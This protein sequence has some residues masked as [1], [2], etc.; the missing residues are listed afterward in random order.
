MTKKG[1]NY[2]QT[3]VRELKQIIS[4]LKSCNRRLKRDKQRLISELQTL[5][6]GF[7]ES[8]KYINEE[9]ETIPI[10]DIVKYFARKRREEKK[11]LSDLKKQS[12]AKK[13]KENRE[14][15]IKRFQTW[16][17]RKSREYEED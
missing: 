17:K 2:P 7:N 4:E 15:V 5:K 9:L 12:R 3:E 14:E 16:I 10:E 8:I 13:P 11:R 6:D 1:R